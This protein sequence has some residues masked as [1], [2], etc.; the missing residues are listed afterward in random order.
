MAALGSCSVHWK[1]HPRKG[2]IR[3]R[4]LFDVLFSRGKKIVHPY[5]Y[6]AVITDSIGFLVGV[7]SRQHVWPLTQ[8]FLLAILQENHWHPAWIKKSITSLSRV[9]YSLHS[10]HLQ[11]HP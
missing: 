9:H 7:L 1:S 11:A 2:V 6:N 10:F 5:Q 4:Q 3:N 8:V